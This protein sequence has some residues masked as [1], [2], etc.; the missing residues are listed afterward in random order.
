MG[1]DASCTLTCDG[2]TSRG[3]AWLEH[4]DLVF[5]GPTRLAIPLASITSA[6]ARDGTLH[7][8]FG[9]RSA[10]FTIGS[11][12][13]KWAARIMNPPSRLDKLGVKQGMS[14][15]AIGIGDARFADEVKRRG[16]KLRR[17]APA[18]S[19]PADM[20]FYGANHRDA[21]MRLAALS[22]MIQQ[23]GA[24]WVVRPK[25]RAEIT[26]AETMAAGKRA[27]LVDVKVVSFS[28]T[29]TAEKFMIPVAR[30]RG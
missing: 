22:K 28:E 8:R 29:H 11:A 2:T 10:T 12:A 15:A 26:E 14:I 7:V 23:N 19:R 30:R 18:A 9:D 20:I 24:I 3:T 1:Y 17:S 4:K 6:T 13:E 5:R 27:G 21:L 25:G 16:A